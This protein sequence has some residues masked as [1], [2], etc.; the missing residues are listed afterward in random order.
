MRCQKA[1]NGQFDGILLDVDN[2]PDGFIQL[3]NERLYCDWELRAACTA[4][5][6][7][8]VLAIWSAYGDDPFFCRLEK[9]GVSGIGLAGKAFSCQRAAK[10]VTLASIMRG[11]PRAPARVKASPA[12][13]DGL[14]AAREACPLPGRRI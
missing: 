3:A 2:G 5:R 7:G 10:R 1:V 8:G 12:R 11:A 13:R 9:A 6:P 14:S 4:L